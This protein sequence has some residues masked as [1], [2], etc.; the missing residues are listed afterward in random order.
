MSQKG[1][2]KKIWATTLR[3]DFDKHRDCIEAF[4]ELKRLSQE[5]GIPFY[6]ALCNAAK[7]YA[8]MLKIAVKT[9]PKRVDKDN[10]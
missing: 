7:V 5:V 4:E 10:Q 2:K 8:E 3:L 6:K 9:N 1:T